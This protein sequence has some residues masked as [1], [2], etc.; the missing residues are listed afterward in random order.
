VLDAVARL[1]DRSL[2]VAE[3]R[4]GESR[5]RL[6]ETIRAYAWQRLEDLREADRLRRR[7]A[8]W[9][10]GLAIRA[11]AEFHGPRQG[12]WLRWAE[13][14]QDN[15]RGA[16]E[17]LCASRDVEGASALC[18]ALWWSWSVHLRWGETRAWCERVLAIPGS[19]EPSVSRANVL[20]GAAI[21]S[22]FL[23]DLVAAEAYFEAGAAMGRHLGMERVVQTFRGSSVIL[24]QFRGEHAAGQKQA[25]ELLAWTR[26]AG[27]Y[28]PEIRA[29]ESVGQGAAS[30]GRYGDAIVV[31][32]QAAGIARREG[33]GWSLARVLETW[34]DVERSRGEHARAGELYVESRDVF[35]E[36]GLGPYPGVL[37]NLGYVVLAAGDRAAAHA[38]FLESMAQFRRAG[39]RRGAAE[40]VIG[41]GCVFAAGGSGEIAA[42]FFGAGDALL[43]AIGSRLWPSNIADYKRWLA[44]ARGRMS[45][46]TFSRAWAEGSSWTLEQA[47]SLAVQQSLERPRAV[48]VL[49]AREREVAELVAR[50]LTNRQV[51]ELLV[52]T[53]KTAANH[54]QRVLDK[55]ELRSRS[56]LADRAAEL[57]LQPR[58]PS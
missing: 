28:W 49:T 8:D 1:V 40:C 51:A 26:E 18:G 21:M 58:T 23:G 43:R 13:R 32:E 48:G 41:L 5:Y 54:V 42:R 24:L 14:E 29:L 20:L 9:L 33:D 27:L 52:V 46:A 6:L 4:D 7:H 45:T 36:L 35:G 56:Q 47:M 50:G 37:H 12:Y 19:G 55:L 17:W 10:I 25:E 34:G 16:L 30:E 2:L 3:E 15:V 31:L 39:D 53:E 11:D 57:G 44:F 38:R 22:V